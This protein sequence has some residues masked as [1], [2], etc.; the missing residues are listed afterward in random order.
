VS[1]HD[2]IVIGAGHN[3]LTTAA[4]L[5]RSGRRVLVLERRDCVGGVAASEEFHPGYHGAGLLHDTGGLRPSVVR[6]LE[7]E[8]HGLALRDRR[9]GLLALGEGG[10]ALYLSGETSEAAAA[11]A[12]LS[13]TDAERY[14]GFRELIESLRPLVDQFLDN[15][16]L[17]LID[18]E[19]NKLR[20][21]ARR[22]L[23]LRRLGRKRMLEFLRLP[24]MSVA[25]WLDE[26]FETGLLKAALAHAAVLG[27]F[28]GPRSPGTNF[29]L[30]LGECGAGPGVSGG[31]PA[32]VAALD[33]A[34]RR[35]GVEIRVDAAVERIL[36]S[37]TG[38]RGVRLESGEELQASV[39]ASACDPKRT[40]LEMLP[41]GIIP[42]RLEQRIRQFRAR[43]TTA[44]VLLAIDGPVVFAG[45]AGEPV[46]FARTGG[47]LDRIE[48]AYDP[49]KY[50]SIAD[51]P[52]LDVHVPTVRCPDL[53]PPGHSVVSVLVHFVPYDLD[54]GWDEPQRERLGRIVVSQLERHL[55]GLISAV[56][57]RRV[58]APPDLDHHYGLTGGQ[59]HHGDHALDQLLVR[60]VPDCS[61]YRTPIRGLYLCGSGSHPGGGLTCAPGA[62]AARTI[63]DD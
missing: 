7:L 39:V 40:L 21:V 37:T 47:D 61:R 32:L 25:D 16:P 48:Q 43:G 6:A 56:R 20:D 2:A 60:P 1:V 8:R 59:I 18:V 42:V 63:L 62:H 30:L 11:I 38:V 13:P 53:A 58:L 34:A 49:I 57:G 50:R 26:W 10:A 28:S 22:A 19:S 17:D 15:P 52:I 27:T 54:A 45:N 9:P 14:R 23:R 55:P 46:E 33:S 29:N 31:A 41:H 3:G 24:P 4:M 44:Q 12:E 5:A 51:A 36:T 35:L